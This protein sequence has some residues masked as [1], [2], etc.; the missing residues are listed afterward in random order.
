MS[1]LRKKLDSLHAVLST[2]A[3]NPVISPPAPPAAPVD[4]TT[5]IIDTDEVA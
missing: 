5:R 3:A 4:S 2:D 1:D